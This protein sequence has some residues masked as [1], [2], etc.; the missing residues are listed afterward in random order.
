MAH[1][2]EAE[3][4]EAQ[5]EMLAE[6]E[7]AYNLIDTNLKQCE[8]RTDATTIVRRDTFKDEDGR[9]P[10]AYQNHISTCKS[11]WAEA[12][13][14]LQYQDDTLGKLRDHSHDKRDKLEDANQLSN[15]TTLDKE[16]GNVAQ[17]NEQLLTCQ[18]GVLDVWQQAGQQ[19]EVVTHKY[20]E[21][22]DW[23]GPGP[24]QIPEVPKPSIDSSSTAGSR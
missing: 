2:K 11:H 16:D 22:G 20:E 23:K 8:L 21:L 19:F 14:Y 13:Y 5:R 3:G 10:Q 6:Q 15:F 9:M 12:R 1:R 17:L 18:R 24:L 7:R 4:L